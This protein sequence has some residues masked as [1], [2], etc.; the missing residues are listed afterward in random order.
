[1]AVYDLYLRAHA[2]FFLA[3]PRWC[4][5]RAMSSKAHRWGRIGDASARTMRG[6]DFNTR[7]D[8]GAVMAYCAMALIHVAKDY[9]L[10][11]AAIR[12]AVEANPNDMMVVASA[13]IVNKHCGDVTAALT[14]LHRAIQ[15]NPRD[16][17]AA[18][19]LTGIAHVHMILGEFTEA[20]VWA[21]RSRTLSPDYACNLWMLVAANAH[22]GRPTANGPEPVLRHPRRPA[23]RWVGVAQSLTR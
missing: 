19:I 4:S 3:L 20:L 21:T 14:H 15:L 7:G 8:D 17:R 13:G 5:C 11:M 6:V 9:D 22:L 2:T 12:S 23:P 18:W 16:P 10:G 1:M